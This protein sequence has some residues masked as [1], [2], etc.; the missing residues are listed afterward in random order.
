MVQDIVA[1]FQLPVSVVSEKAMTGGVPIIYFP[2]VDKREFVQ[3]WVIRSRTRRGLRKKRVPGRWEHG[4]PDCRTP[5][6]AG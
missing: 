6:P 1:E 4:V 5:V 3:L 2:P